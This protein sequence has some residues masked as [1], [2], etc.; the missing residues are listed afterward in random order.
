MQSDKPDKLLISQQLGK[1]IIRPRIHSVQPPIDKDN[2]F[3]GVS[4]I[5]KLD[6][7]TEAF[8]QDLYSN[9]SFQIIKLT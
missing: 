4:R 9:T 2:E 7:K 5:L 8:Y 3:N 1:I 6:S